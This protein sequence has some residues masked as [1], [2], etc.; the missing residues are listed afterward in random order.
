MQCKYYWIVL[1]TVHVTAFCLGGPFFSG[2]GVYTT[3]TDAARDSEVKK[4]PHLSP[5]AIL[6]RGLEIVFSIYT[7]LG[8]TQTKIKQTKQHFLNTT[9]ITGQFCLLSSSEVACCLL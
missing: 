7:Y 8:L 9:N 6:A 2:H 5:E 3:T 4:S 1:Y